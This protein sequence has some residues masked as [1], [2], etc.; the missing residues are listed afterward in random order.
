MRKTILS[1]A[2]PSLIQLSVHPAAAATR[3]VENSTYSGIAYLFSGIISQT[4]PGT[5]SYT[6]DEV[7]LALDGVT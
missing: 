6:D 1:A 4:V 2:A 3:S 5:I 7:T